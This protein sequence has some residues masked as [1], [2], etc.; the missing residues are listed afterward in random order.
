MTILYLMQMALCL[1]DEVVMVA[2]AVDSN[3]D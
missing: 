2:E 3:L 1:K